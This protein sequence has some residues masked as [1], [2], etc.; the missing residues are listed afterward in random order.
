MNKVLIV[1]TA[2]IGDV[3]L[4]TPVIEQVARTWPGAE[5]HF[6]LRKGNEGL[7]SGHPKIQKVIVRNKKDGKWKSLW[8]VL[9]EVRQEKYDLV[10]NLH[11][12]LSSGIIAGFSGGK[13]VCGFGKNPFSWRYHHEVTHE[14]GN[15][16]H[17][18]DRNLAVIAHLTDGKR[19]LPK[20]YP[21]STDHALVKRERPYVSLAPTSVWFTK[22]WP[23]EQ[24]TRLIDS[25]PQHLDILLLGAPGDAPACQQIANGSLH[26]NIE[27]LAGKL[28]L[29]QSAALMQGASMNYVNDSAPMHLASA[30]NAPVTAIFCST[31]PRFGFGPL[32]DQSHV[33]ETPEELDCRPCGL[34]GFKA[35]PKGHFKC[36]QVNFQDFP[37]L[38]MQD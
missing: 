28:N 17:E 24:W 11:R 25:L 4:A 32:S 26:P 10:V 30:M 36:S 13:H 34:H 14:I 23:A 21:N 18:I 3:I 2:F 16:T 37:V 6:L 19:L 5:I 1:Q 9:K 20:L 35:C 12:F 15:G 8:K 7:L 29:L 31:V 38:S 22:Q 27:I 33:V